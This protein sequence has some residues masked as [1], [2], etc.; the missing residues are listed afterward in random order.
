MKFLSAL[1]RKSGTSFV[2]LVLMLG[3]EVE[4]R[5]RVRRKVLLFCNGRLLISL[6]CRCKVK[7]SGKYSYGSEC[8]SDE[9]R[10]IP[11]CFTYQPWIAVDH[12]HT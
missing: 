4:N 2:V 3:F 1:R 10:A 7:Y 5:P 12:E 8:L 6:S 11:C 9:S